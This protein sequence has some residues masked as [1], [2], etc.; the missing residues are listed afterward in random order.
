M[1]E[2]RTS[3][4]DTNSK[5][6][7]QSLLLRLKLFFRSGHFTK[8]FPTILKDRSDFSEFIFFKHDGSIFTGGEGIGVL[9]PVN[10]RVEHSLSVQL[11]QSNIVGHVVRVVLVV[12]DHICNSEFLAVL[13]EVRGIFIPFIGPQPEIVGMK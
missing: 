4:I 10:L 6:P 12:H 11:H 7:I 2:I 3:N 8:R 5:K 1:Q 9:S 13:V